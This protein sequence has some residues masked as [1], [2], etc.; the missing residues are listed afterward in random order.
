MRAVVQRV[1]EARVEVEGQTV[2]QIGHGLLVLLGVGRGDSED[3]ARRMA[4]KV[5]ELRIFSDDQGKFN[6]SALDLGGEI[7]V[8]SQFTLY[9]YCRRGRRPSFTEAAPPEVALPLVEAFV[10]E[11]RSM[12]LQVAT[13]VFQAHMLVELKNDGPVTVVLDSRELFGL[14]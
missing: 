1:R 10:R 12:G 11:L 5:A 3:V 6:L 7:M 8:V 14:P 13:G 2:G 4:R 9:A